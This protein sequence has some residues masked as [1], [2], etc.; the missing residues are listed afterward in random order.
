MSTYPKINTKTNKYNLRNNNRRLKKNKPD[1]S[2]S[3]SDSSTGSEDDSDYETLDDESEKSSSQ[4]SSNHSR[5][6]SNEGSEDNADYDS[7]ELHKYLSKIFPSKYMNDKVK[8]D[9][10]KFKKRGKPEPTSD[11]DES[12][13]E[14]IQKIKTRL[15]MNSSSKRK[16]K[17]KG[18]KRE[19]S[20]DDN[21]EDE[22]SD[23][24]RK[25]KSRVKSRVKSKGKD[26][27]SKSHSSSD[28]T[29][30]TDT[31][32]SDYNENEDEINI[33]F[34]L[35][36]NLD[37]E[38]YEEFY[39]EKE[40]KLD[41]EK[42]ECGS[43]D[44]KM[45]M[46]EKYEKISESSNNNEN[47][48]TTPSSPSKSKSKGKDKKSKHRKS[49]H[50][51]TESGSNESD[52]DNVDVT[53]VEEEYLD[54][55]EL[56]KHLSEKIK[57]K[58]HSK[59]LKNALSKCK[60]EINKLIKSA[61][62]K[63]T[64]SYYRLINNDKK[65]TNEI[66]YFKKKLS[67]KEQIHIVNDLKEINKNMYVEKP[68]RLSILQSSMPPKLKAIALQKLN[69]L[70]TMEPG[71]SEYHKIKNWVDTFM[72][73][74]FDVHKNL[75]ISMSDGKEVCSNFIKNAKH[76]LD[77]CVYGLE[78]AKMQI[79]QMLGQWIANPASIGSAIAI[80]GPPGTGKTSLIKDGVSKIL[81]REFAFIALGGAGDSSFLEGHSY[82]YE[83][84]TWGKIVQILIET[85]CMNPVIYFDELDKISNSPRGQEIIGVLTHLIDTSQNTQYHDKYF[86]E[87]DFDLSKCLFIFSYNDET[88]VNPILKDRMYCIQTNGYQAKEK[89]VIARNYLLPK[90]RE[91]VNFQKDEI[92]IPDETINHI[93]T[94]S[95]FTNTE[96]GV[97]NLKRCLE[98]IHTKLN[99]F[100]LVDLDNNND[101]FKHLNLKVTFPFT[102]TK[103]NIDIILK[104][105]LNQ[106]QSLFNSMYI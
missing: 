46:K 34:K 67:N 100:R 13:D 99:L 2:S 79:M 22:E 29:S 88:L 27:K 74:P 15:K 54:L 1:S 102:V 78:D 38:Y 39:N 101:L 7:V 82:T 17:Q 10:K 92:I 93:I 87:V 52:E 60:E 30:D 71:D 56:K 106:R 36:S 89:I 104:S 24:D 9:K 37:N 96:D 57:N 65:N 95:G 77:E 51:D 75:S 32:D 49:K 94:T 50:A 4:S 33:V 81:G 73:I 31:S 61:R 86:S 23:Y 25:P 35:N 85:K 19:N 43:E 6:N 80:K 21:D 69:M 64:R 105:D 62:F 98:I 53:D 26:K 72:K 47:A 84:S 14:S 40:M 12:E 45:F 76:I 63:N 68:Y 103:D 8:K 66:D 55:I 3:E 16:S 18:K 20:E 91:Q 97:R 48:D 11:T 70:K 41:N 42:E 83:G 44:E 28:E 5:K 59:L 58:P 90:I